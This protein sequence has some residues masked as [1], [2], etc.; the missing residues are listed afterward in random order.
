MVFEGILEELDVKSVCNALLLTQ[1]TNSE[2]ESEV[3][4]EDLIL[5]HVM[6][7]QS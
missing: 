5:C 7:L 4:I 2:D 6:S 3:I 1:H